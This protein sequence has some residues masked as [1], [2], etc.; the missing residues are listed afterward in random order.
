MLVKELEIAQAMAQESSN[1]SA[2]IKATEVK[3]RLLGLNEP[4]EQKVEHKG[5]DIKKITFK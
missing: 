4:D 5:L 3:A 1:P 2:F